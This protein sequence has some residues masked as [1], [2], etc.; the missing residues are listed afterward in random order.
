MANSKVFTIFAGV[1]GA[2]KSTL[3]ACDNSQ[4]LGVRLNADEIVRNNGADWR[5]TQAQV[6]AA[7]Q[8]LLLQQQCFDGGL[9]CNR[10]TT[11]CGTNIIKSINLAKQLGYA[12]HLRYVGVS[13]PQIAIDR[14]NKR[15]SLGGHGVSEATIEHRYE[16]SADNFRKI[17]SLCD[18]INVY[19]NSGSSLI[20]VA[21]TVDGQFVQTRSD[22]QWVNDLL[23]GLI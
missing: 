3:Y 9:S 22:I 12:I 11:L 17:V 2:G 6:K 4:H 7:K 18:N 15:I 21:Y 8:L 14:V 19:D 16:T 23:V 1:N 5:D 20:L 13:N 10:E